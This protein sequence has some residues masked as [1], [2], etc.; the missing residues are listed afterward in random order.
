MGVRT[1]NEEHFD[2]LRE[3]GNIGAGNAITAISSLLNKKVDMVVPVV[4]MVEFKDIA[5]SIGGAENLIISVLVKTTG[6]INGL[7]LF[8]IE[9]ETAH[10]FVNTLLGKAHSSY[11][12]FSEM[13][14]SVLQEIGNMVAGSYLGSLATLTGKK[15]TPSVPYL[16]IDMAGAILSV[17][18][19]EFGKVADHVLFIESIFQTTDEYAS[20]YF[21]LVQEMESYDVILKSLGV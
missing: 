20:G 18:A 4:K 12:D 7:M 1:I 16:A 19:V 5:D 15:I 6:D 14:M 3:I 9:Q 11:L 10:V 17:P 21:L 8:C 13:E 2:L